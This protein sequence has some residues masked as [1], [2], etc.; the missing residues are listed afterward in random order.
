[1]RLKSKIVQSPERMKRD[2]AELSQ[3]VMREGITVN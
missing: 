1:M 2:M 3:A